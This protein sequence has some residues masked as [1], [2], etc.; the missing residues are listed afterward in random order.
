MFISD[1]PSLILDPQKA[2]PVLRDSLPK[3]RSLIETLSPEQMSALVDD[4]GSQ[5][6]LRLPGWEEVL[7]KELFSLLEKPKA[8]VSFGEEDGIFVALDTLPTQTLVREGW[9]REILRQSQVLRRDAG[10]QMDQRIHLA[11]STSSEEI[12]SA[13][14]EW[15][16]LVTEETLAVDLAESLDSPLLVKEVE[17]GPG[18]VR[19]ELTAA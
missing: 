15:E 8:N 14:S 7:P 10:L 5:D 16:E 18:S 1:R 2:G 9:I 17:V 19:L 4:Y 12:R 3:V 6:G 13:V 11:I